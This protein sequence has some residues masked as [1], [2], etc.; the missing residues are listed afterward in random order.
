[1]IKIKAEWTAQCIEARPYTSGKECFWISAKIKKK[2]E[3]KGAAWGESLV[4]EVHTEFANQMAL[5]GA[6]S[7]M[8]TVLLNENNLQVSVYI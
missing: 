5:K 7:P 1:M 2:K 3:K 8:G 4:A 6:R